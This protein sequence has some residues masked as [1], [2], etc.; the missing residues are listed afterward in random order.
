MNVLDDYL[1]R[2]ALAEQ[3][4]KTIRTLER[5]ERQRIGPPI[6]RIGRRPFY[7]IDG[8]RNWLRRCEMPMVRERTR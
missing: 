6:T 5:W 3:L 4:N 2:S 7:R 1:P 8:V